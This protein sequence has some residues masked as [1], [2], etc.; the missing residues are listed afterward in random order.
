MSQPIEL[1]LVKT[2]TQPNLNWSWVW[3]K[4]GNFCRLLNY[5]PDKFTKYH[6]WCIFLS[7]ICVKISPNNYEIT[8]IIVFRRVIHLISQNTDSGI[9]KMHICEVFFST[10]YINIIKINLRSGKG[11]Q[12]IFSIER[13]WSFFVKVIFWLKWLKQSSPSRIIVHSKIQ[14]TPTQVKLE[15]KLGCDNK[16]KGLPNHYQSTCCS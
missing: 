13:N 9:Y 4:I 1:I 7:N 16:T 11:T 12:I 6:F 8:L 10:L 3:C 15:L 5:W 14:V 2:S